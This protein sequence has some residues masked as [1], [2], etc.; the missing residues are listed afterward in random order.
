VP[1]QS[2]WLST[3]ALLLTAVVIATV[4]TL[5]ERRHRVHID[6]ANG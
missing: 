3:P 5:V 2:S 1:D 6:Q 4:A